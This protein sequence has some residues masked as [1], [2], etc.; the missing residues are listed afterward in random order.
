MKTLIALSAIIIS[1]QITHAQAGAQLDVNTPGNSNGYGLVRFSNPSG[2]KVG[3]VDISDIVGNPYYKDG[4]Q[5][6]IIVLSNDKAVQL[7]QVKVNLCNNEVHYIDSL[8]KEMA[9]DDANVKKVVLL[10]LKDTSKTDAIFLV[11]KGYQG[12]PAGILMQVLN[13]GNTELLKINAVEV[14]KRDYDVMSGKTSYTFNPNISYAF[15]KNGEL[16]PCKNLT[17]A[18]VFTSL[19]PDAGANTW[20]T[21]SKNKLKNEKDVIAFLDYYNKPK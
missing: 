5:P 13:Q 14:K 2:S 20:L 16:I 1:A 10:N 12:K 21:N 15:Y 3:D 6:G 19:L 7:E 8:G 18:D 17:K 9:V 11:I 4:W